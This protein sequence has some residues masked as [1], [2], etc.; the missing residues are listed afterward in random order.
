M[1]KSLCSDDGEFCRR[2]NWCS[3]LENYEASKAKSYRGCKINDKDIDIS[4]G[5]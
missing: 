4:S 3:K 5:G 1:N 2:S